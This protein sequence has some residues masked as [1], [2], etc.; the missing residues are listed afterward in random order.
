MTISLVQA[1]LIGLIYYLGTTGNPVFGILGSHGWMRPLVCGTA[2][3]FVLGDP[4]M[5]CIMG[6]AITLPY[7][8]F[9]SAGASMPMDPAL[10]GTLGT[11][12][13][14]VAKVEPSVAITLAV[15][16]GILGTLLWVAHMSVNIVFYSHE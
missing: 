14:L 4:T 2:V 12:F 9:I 16:I 15:P 8:A 10:A 6:A 1:C 3:G 5:G 7:L 11:A 13:G